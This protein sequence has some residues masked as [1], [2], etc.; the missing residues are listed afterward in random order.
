MLR[1]RYKT[2][3]AENDNYS[4]CRILILEIFEIM[5]T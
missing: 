4:V 1:D 3:F 2:C 5:K